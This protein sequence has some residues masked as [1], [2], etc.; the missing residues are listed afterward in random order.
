MSMTTNVSSGKPAMTPII[1][2]PAA[3]SAT[4]VAGFRGLATDGS[5]RAGVRFPAH[6][7]QLAR[8]ISRHFLHGADRLD[9]LRH[10]AADSSVLRPAI[11]RPRPR[12][13]RAGH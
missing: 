13:R 2:R 1:N 3:T 8:Q 11:W 9:R 10:R 7:L 5:V 12:V 6:V 4:L